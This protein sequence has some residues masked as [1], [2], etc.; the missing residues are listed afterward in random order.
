MYYKNFITNITFTLYAISDIYNILSYGRIKTYVDTN[1]LNNNHLT[2][3]SGDFISPSKYTNI[4][5]GQT[6]MKTFDLVPINIASL[7]N[8]EFDINSKTLNS[9]LNSSVKTKFISTN[10]QYISNTIPYYIL[11][12]VDQLNQINMTFGFIG[13]CGDNFYHKY[14]IKFV[15]DSQINKTINSVIDIYKPDFIVGL[16]HAD[17]EQDLIWIDKFPQI[18]MI[19][20]GHIHKYD[21]LKYKGVPIIRTGENADSI[22]QIDWDIN[23]S[24]QINLIDIH[25]LEPDKLIKELNF[26]AEKLFIESNKN[27]LFNLRVPYSSLDPRNKQESLPQLFCELISNYYN[28]SITILNAGIFRKKE[29]FHNKLTFGDLQSILPF[30]DTV[31]SISMDLNDLITGI[32]YSNAKYKGLGGYIQSNIN[33]NLIKKFYDVELK[34]NQ[35]YMINVSMVKLMLFGIDYNPYFMKYLKDVKESDGISIHNIFISYHG[36]TF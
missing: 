34:N 7:G 17:L 24:Y 35:T 11:N 8:H 16:T 9:S 12:H 23:K 22:F 19:L 14:D 21:Y 28:T 6:I 15:N 31:I 1:S 5:G 13:L 32:E 36:M 27:V 33:L 18:N 29:I 10:I 25:K 26:E 20:G 3:M 2:L 30:Q 4:D